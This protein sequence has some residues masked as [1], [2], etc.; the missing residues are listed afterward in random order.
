MPD[1]TI[2]HAEE[3]AVFPSAVEHVNEKETLP[4]RAC[5]FSLVRFKK[6]GVSDKG[7]FFQGNSSGPETEDTD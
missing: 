1:F 6:A 5:C 4:L 3:A 7:Y 2:S